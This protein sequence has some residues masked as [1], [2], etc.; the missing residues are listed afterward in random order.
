MLGF[1]NELTPMVDYIFL[2]LSCGHLRQIEGADTGIKSESSQD[3]SD[4]E[5]ARIVLGQQVYQTRIISVDEYVRDWLDAQV[6]GDS[7]SSRSRH[8]ALSVQVFVKRVLYDRLLGPLVFI[9]RPRQMRKFQE[10]GA[11]TTLH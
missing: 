2:H 11:V 4:A 9:Q 6:F 8:L 5:V 3:S 1:T 10:F 7:E